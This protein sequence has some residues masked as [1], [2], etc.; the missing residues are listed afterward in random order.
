MKN[1]KDKKI[2]A[3]I[4]E[5]NPLH[6]GHRLLLEESKRLSD[7][8][9]VILSGDYVQ[10]GEPAI[11]NKYTRTKMAL[12]SGADLV[13]ELPTVYALSSAEGFSRG[14]IDIINSLN[15]CD[16]LLFGSE[17][18]NLDTLNTL[19][20]LIS[21]IMEHENSSI[22]ESLKSGLNYPAAISEE[23][24]KLNLDFSS[25]LTP[26]N[27]LAIEYLKA[28]SE[29]DSRVTP[30][31]ISRS[32]NG[33]SNEA[34]SD[35]EYTSATSIRN[36][37]KTSESIKSYVPQSAF[38]LYNENTVFND[39]FS[40]VVY[41]SLLSKGKA[42]L[43]DYLDVSSELKD[44]IIN[45]LNSFTTLSDFEELLKTK[46]LTR[47]RINRALFHILLDIKKE[48]A[49]LTPSYARILGFK[50]SSKELLSLIKKNSSIPLISKLKDANMDRLLNIDIDAAF[51]YEKVSCGYL[52]EYQQSPIIL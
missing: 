38:A 13:I 44:R 49:Y 45:N 46:S 50:K 2:T 10:R 18:G 47:A 15:V 48:D 28:L 22:K 19:K 7:Y 24:N 23:L 16:Y 33:Y 36:A 12:I 43:E 5:F 25:A 27:I 35:N 52:N 40:Q 30:Y 31:T 3:I 14:A 32:D 9:I 26:N 41:Y 34:L 17:A 1:L 37:L 29:T 21:Q 4:A 11:F 51:L 20:D 8:T 6:N 39:S 42:N